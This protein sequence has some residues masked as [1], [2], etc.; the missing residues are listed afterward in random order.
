MKKLLATFLSIIVLL[1]AANN[2][3]AQDIVSS[4]MPDYASITAKSYYSTLT[5]REQGARQVNDLSRANSINDA[6]QFLSSNLNSFNMNDLNGVSDI[7][8]AIL[9]SQYEE[10]ENVILE[11]AEL[12]EQ[13]GVL[14]QNILEQINEYQND[15]RDILSSAAN[16]PDGTSSSGNS[17]SGTQIDPGNLVLEDKEVREL[18]LPDLIKQISA[19]SN[20]FVFQEVLPQIGGSTRG[21][22]YAFAVLYLVFYGYKIF[23]GAAFNFMEV[24]TALFIIFVV[25]IL[26]T[27]QGVGYLR[28]L[29]F[30]AYSSSAMFS[31]AI[32]DTNVVE[33][34]SEFEKEGGYYKALA[35]LE[36]MFFQMVGLGEFI[37]KTYVGIA[38]WKQVIGAALVAGA[39]YIAIVSAFGSLVVYYGFLFAYAVIALNVL[40]CLAPIYLLFFAFSL[41][42]GLAIQWLRAMFNYLLIPIIATITLTLAVF[43]INNFF[44]ELQQLLDV[45]QGAEEADAQAL[46]DEFPWDDIIGIIG[47]TLIM[48]VLA[49]RVGDMAAHLTGGSSGNLGA[50]A[51]DTL[52]S[53]KQDFKTVAVAGLGFMA[54]KQAG[55]GMMDKMKDNSSGSQAPDGF[56]QPE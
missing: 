35:F 40:L 34:P 20:M 56:F 11:A 32:V 50:L 17:A 30:T 45:I 10:F 24:G 16:S 49:L 53:F 15:R 54:A 6:R 23:R 38:G 36:S 46:K 12:I 8:A 51:Q 3:S 9:R 33:W 28:S 29:Y 21:L 52:K 31:S 37:W 19:F 5:T 44:L 13:G 7:N 22:L 48:Q 27:D 55:A 43:V 18:I 26:L 47:V 41:T 4:A 39:T 42:R 1:A 2:V 25:N 14:T